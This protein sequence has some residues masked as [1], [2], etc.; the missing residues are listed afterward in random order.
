MRKQETDYILASILKVFDDVATL[1]I[2]AGNPF[3]VE[4]WDQLI[5]VEIRPP[6]YEL[7]PFQ[8]EILA[9][10][11]INENRDVIE[12]LVA[13]GECDSIYKL[14]EDLHFSVN[15]SSYRNTYALTL[16]K[17]DAPSGKPGLSGA[18]HKVE[19]KSDELDLSNTFL[20]MIID[21]AEKP[22]PEGAKEK[23]ASDSAHEMKMEEEPFDI[24]IDELNIHDLHAD[25]EE[26]LRAMD[27]DEPELNGELSADIEYKSP[28]KEPEDERGGFYNGYGTIDEGELTQVFEMGIPGSKFQRKKDELSKRTDTTDKKGRGSFGVFKK[29]GKL[30]RSERTENEGEPDFQPIRRLA[31]LEIYPENKEPVACTVFSR[32]AVEPGEILRVQVFAHMAE[33][34]EDDSPLPDKANLSEGISLDTDIEQGTEL[35]FELVVR[36]GVVHNPVEYLEWQGNTASVTFQ[37]EI[38]RNCSKE[39]L[40]GK[41]IISQNS[42]PIG[43]IG[44]QVEVTLIDEE[45]SSSDRTSEPTGTVRRY[46]YAFLSYVSENRSAAL[47]SALMLSSLNIA[48]PQELLK[49]APRKRWKEKLY[50]KIDD[51]DVFFL[52]W[53]PE[54][55][56]SEWV[57]RESLYALQRKARDDDKPPEIIPV[58]IKSSPQPPDEL[59]HLRFDERPAYLKSAISY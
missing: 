42:I 40:K 30:F 1:D 44:L 28:P 41:V 58:M 43:H 53:S 27:A 15:I 39:T 24:G 14:S 9:L 5:G 48:V 21:R 20:D 35:T 57:R 25:S 26:E 8:T 46:Q 23:V 54:A 12:T 22:V 31:P 11:L 29:L 52:F 2:T 50:L 18:G 38:P 56:K 16:R 37:V 32:P 36:D 51:A 4:R 3:R 34:L 47:R 10:N 59:K 49:L 33:L 13:R 45:A 6:F 17:T 7:T 55:A 19:P